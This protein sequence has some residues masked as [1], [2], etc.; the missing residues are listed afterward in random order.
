MALC[1]EKVEMSDWPPRSADGLHGA[2]YEWDGPYTAVRCICGFYRIT[3]THERA[4]MEYM[5]H[6]PAGQ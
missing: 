2:T 5:H 3:D 4:E 1:R 6:L